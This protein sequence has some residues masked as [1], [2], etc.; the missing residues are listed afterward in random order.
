MI[1]KQNRLIRYFIYPIADQPKSQSGSTTSLPTTLNKEQ[2]KQ[3][4]TRREQRKLAK[5]RKKESHSQGTK[6]QLAEEEQPP[7]GALWGSNNELKL[8]REEWDEKR[9]DLIDLFGKVRDEWLE[10]DF[11]TWI[12]ANR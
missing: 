4:D 11:A 9:D 12:G 5:E 6:T 3:N 7:R 2:W 1:R 8:R 10:Q